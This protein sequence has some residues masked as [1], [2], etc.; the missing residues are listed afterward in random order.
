[1]RHQCGAGVARR[2]V[3]VNLSL[4]AML[5][6]ASLSERDVAVSR[7]PGQGWQVWEVLH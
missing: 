4:T 6:S 3:I 7:L 1:V 5:P 2:T